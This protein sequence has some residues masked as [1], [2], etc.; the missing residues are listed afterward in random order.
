MYFSDP[1]GN[2]VEPAHYGIEHEAI[3]S[4][5]DLI[6]FEDLGTAGRSSPSLEMK[7]WRA[8]KTAVK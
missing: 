6:T 2:K 8:Q 5:H 3:D 7:V 4:A 1:E